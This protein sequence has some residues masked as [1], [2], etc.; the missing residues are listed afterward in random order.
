MH[1]ITTPNNDTLYSQAWIDLSSGPVRITVPPTGG[2]YFSLA[3]MDMFLQ[4]H[5][6]DRRAQQR[7]PER[8][9]AVA[10]DRAA[11]A[12]GCH[13]RRE[14]RRAAHAAPTAPVAAS[15]GNPC[16]GNLGLGLGADPGRRR[17]GHGRRPCDP[18]WAGGAGQAPGARPAG[19][20]RARRRVERLFLGRAGPDRGQSPARGR[21]RLLSPHRAPAIGLPSRGF[22]ER[23]RFRRCGSWGISRRE[24]RRGQGRT[25]G[26]AGAGHG[27]VQGL[28]L[29]QSPI[30]T[31]SG[32]TI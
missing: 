30:S 4:Q 15:G 28:G 2:R 20:C 8:G 32:R 9:G 3:L 7:H 16:P 6:G 23:A 17:G 31:T 26:A 14:H 13:R 18:G 22:Q 1:A 11:Q 12:D 10:A 21:R 27:L 25:A 5:P 19:L 29:S 24:D